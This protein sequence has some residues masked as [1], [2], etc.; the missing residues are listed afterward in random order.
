VVL[1][2]PARQCAGGLAEVVLGLVAWFS[3]RIS[4]T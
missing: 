2:V 1:S 4:V 3:S